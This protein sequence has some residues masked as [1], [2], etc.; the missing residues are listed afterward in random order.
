MTPDD[1]LL[2]KGSPGIRRR[3]LDLQLAQID[4]LYVHHL[5]RYYRAMKQRNVLLRRK[6]IDSIEIW[7]SQ[8]ATSGEYIIGQRISAVSDLQE[9]SSDLHAVLTGEKQELSLKYQATAISDLASHFKRL[10]RRELELGSTLTGPHRDDLI[11]AIGGKE[12]RHFAS[13]GQQRSCVAA[14]KFAEWERLNKLA[15]ISPL[16]LIDDVGISLD[17][18]RVDRLFSHV[19][20]LGQ[21]FLTTTQTNTNL[22]LIHDLDAVFHKA[23]EIYL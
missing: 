17:H 7:E 3:F 15:D 6:S 21:V 9:K 16:M 13:E 22:G 14:L 5:C 2:V 18:S 19:Q 12:A 1:A 4:P 11:I 8:M 23:E 20:T 10:R